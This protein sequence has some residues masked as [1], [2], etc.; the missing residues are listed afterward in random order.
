ML[1]CDN[2]DEEMYLL[3][4]LAAL[5]C[6]TRLVYYLNKKSSAIKGKKNLKVPLLFS[7]GILRSIGVRPT[8]LEP[9]LFEGLAR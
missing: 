7:G 9:A 8:N 6:K 3:V 4:L 2:C 1:N 5:S